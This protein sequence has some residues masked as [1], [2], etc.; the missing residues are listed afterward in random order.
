MPRAQ[1][2]AIS[3]TMSR[4]FAE[5][6]SCSLKLLGFVP[7]PFTA[8]KRAQIPSGTPTKYKT[9]RLGTPV[10][11]FLEGCLVILTAIKDAENRYL[12]SI[13]LERYHNAF[14][15]AGYS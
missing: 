5:Q 7:M 3:R 13:H 11:L 9:E 6:L 14:S 1:K 10:I 12:V 2:G 4:T 15:V 8:I